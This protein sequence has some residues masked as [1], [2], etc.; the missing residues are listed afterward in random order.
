MYRQC[1]QPTVQSIALSMLVFGL[2]GDALGGFCYNVVCLVV[3][4]A[5]KSPLGVELVSCELSKGSQCRI[6]RVPSRSKRII[7]GRKGIEST[8]TGRSDRG[9]AVECVID[10][11]LG[12][13]IVSVKKN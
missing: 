7:A 5:N 6:E 8:I 11:E 4:D 9:T 12:G 13:T 10:G 1:L 3:N 2:Q